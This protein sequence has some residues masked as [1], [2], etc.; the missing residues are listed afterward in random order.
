MVDDGLHAN[1]AVRHHRAP[2]ANVSL[3]RHAKNAGGSRYALK[4]KPLAMI[5]L[6][7]LHSQKRDDPQSLLKAVGIPTSNQFRYPAA[8]G[9]GK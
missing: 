1:R 5:D 6:P 9:N 3:S 2:F 4:L 7:K 8:E